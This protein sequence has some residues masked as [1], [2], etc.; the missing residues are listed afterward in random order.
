MAKLYVTGINSKVLHCVTHTGNA[1]RIYFDIVLQRTCL[2]LGCVAG[3]RFKGN[4]SIISTA[5]VDAKYPMLVRTST[6]VIR[7]WSS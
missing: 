7:L 6:I 3:H 2:K 5:L 1:Q 4:Q